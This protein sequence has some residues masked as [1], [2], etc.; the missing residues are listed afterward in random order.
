VEPTP[1]D[2]EYAEVL[3]V[4]I[5]EYLRD[6]RAGNGARHIVRELLTAL[7][8]STEE[9]GRMFQVS[10]E[11]AQRWEQGVVAVPAK[12][13]A[14]ITLAGDALTRLRAFFQPERL[15]A[16]IR[17]RPAPLFEGESAL[18]W[19]LRGL[20]REV[21]DRYDRLLSYEPEVLQQ[22]AMKEA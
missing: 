18:D 1:D 3:E 15:P 4:A 22:V 21:V 9:L 16:V 7:S 13:Q 5:T 8:I 14:D 17:R 6:A 20:I 2:R 12:K 11:T 19:I 10:G